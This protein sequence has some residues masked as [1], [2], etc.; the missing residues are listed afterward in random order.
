MIDVGGVQWV[1]VVSGESEALVECLS[2]RKG[3]SG[4]VI[5]SMGRYFNLSF[6]VPHLSMSHQCWLLRFCL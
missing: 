3:V 5:A 1:S 6:R 4:L 2:K